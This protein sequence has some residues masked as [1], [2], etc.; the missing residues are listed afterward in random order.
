[1][2][3]AFINAREQLASLLNNAKQWREAADELRSILRL[4][5]GHLETRYLLVEALQEL[6]DHE[7]VAR[8]LFE[9]LLLDPDNATS[10]Y[11][12]GVALFLRGSDR[13]RAKAEFRRALQLKPDYDDAR[14]ALAAEP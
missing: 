11:N 6:G 5:P 4:R 7:S 14:K 2:N 1:L 8:E 12:L 13:E 3:P 10:H 9:C